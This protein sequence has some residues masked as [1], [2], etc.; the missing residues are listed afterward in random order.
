MARIRTATFDDAAAVCELYGRN[1]LG[2][3]DPAEWRGRWEKYPFAPEFQDIPIGWVLQ[4]DDGLLVGIFAN[5]HM[6]Y[7][8][9]GRRLRCCI[10]CE[11]AVDA[12]SRG[13]SLHLLDRFLRQKGVDI[14]LVGSASPVTEGILTRLKIPRI[15]AP[16]YE[17]PM[18]W[19]VRPRQFAAAALRKKAVKGAEALAGPAG[20]GL[21]VA[22]FVR[23]SGRGQ[24]GS[25]VR[26]LPVFDE[27]FDGFCER[28]CIE[29]RHLQ[30]VRSRAVL[31]WRFRAP[32][33]R[34]EM[35][36]ITAEQDGNLLG[37][38]VMVRRLADDL[39][40]EVCDVADLQ[41]LGENPSTFRDLLLGALRAA[42]ESG[43]GTLKLLTANPSKQTVA[44]RLRPHVYHTPNWQLFYKIRDATL[45]LQL[46]APEAW[47]FSPFDNY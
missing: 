18:L 15:P 41:A 12:A 21:G 39:L 35:S 8:L 23:G 44:E 11:W 19:A 36:V 42:R 46:A 1:G 38:A 22:D 9:R 29:S 6:L 26:S 27:R 34:G 31:E 45:A 37:Y 17:V 7:E 28:L 47:D 3:V 25:T 4:E 10:G 40:T 30:A 2:D 43:A 13:M 14:C 24:P 16:G 5:V 32:A 20:L 33:S